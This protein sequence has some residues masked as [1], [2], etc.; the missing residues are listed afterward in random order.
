MDTILVGVGEFSASK[1]PGDVIKTFALGSCVGVIFLVPKLRMVGLLHVALPDS[2]INS[3]LY[4][5]KPG[6][7]ADTGIPALLCEMK[8]LGY[9]EKDRTVVKLAG[10]ATIMDPNNTFNI[11]KR[12]C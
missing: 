6:M 3:R 12:N 2:S 1:T 4:R 5:N 7:F 8:L 10:G 9:N 11:G